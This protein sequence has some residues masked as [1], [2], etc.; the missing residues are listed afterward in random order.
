MIDQQIS[1]ALVLYCVDRVN[2]VRCSPRSFRAP[3]STLDRAKVRLTHEDSLKTDEF[4]P[5][6]NAFWHF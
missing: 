3:S 6:S 2:T 1:L 5:P 4:V